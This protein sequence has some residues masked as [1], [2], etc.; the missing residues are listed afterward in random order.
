MSRPTIHVVGLGP[1]GDDL[2]TAS[3]RAAISPAAV[4]LVRPTRPPAA[5]S[6]GPVAI[7]DELYESAETFEELYERI[8]GDLVRLARESPTGSGV[9]AL[10]RAPGVAE[11][12]GETTSARC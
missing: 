9:Y 6:P 4:F 3:A 1:G 12:P 5:A 2:M 10:P 7:Y 8:A 11:G